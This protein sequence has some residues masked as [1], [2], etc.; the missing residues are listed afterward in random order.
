MSMGMEPQMTIPHCQVFSN[1]TYSFR[2]RDYVDVRS[3]TVGL[4]R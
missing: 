1:K 3:S 4:N 2:A